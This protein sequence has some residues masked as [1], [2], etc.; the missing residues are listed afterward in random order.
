MKKQLVVLLLKY[1]LGFGLL[2]LVAWYYW[3]EQTPEGQEVGLAAVLEQRNAP[4]L[5]GPG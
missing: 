4:F 1:G 5:P 2:G 3:H